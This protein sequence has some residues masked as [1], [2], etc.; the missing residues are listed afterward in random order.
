MVR[1][2]ATVERGP[3]YVKCKM[4]SIKFLDIYLNEIVRVLNFS[5]VQPIFIHLI[6]VRCTVLLIFRY[7]AQ[8]MLENAL[9]CRQN[10]RL[11]NRSFCSNFCRQ[12]L[13]K[14]IQ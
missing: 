8:I 11:K 14:P 6:Y 3:A 12:N 1:W 7:S 5:K 13:S 2:R 9:F 4:G 10:V